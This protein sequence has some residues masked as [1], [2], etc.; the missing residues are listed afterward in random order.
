M[1][2]TI[3]G[4]GGGTMKTG[5]I[6]PGVW[7]AVKLGFKGVIDV[8]IGE[9]GLVTPGF[10]LATLLALLPRLPIPDPFPTPTSVRMPPRETMGEIR[11]R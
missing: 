5:V 8:V 4:N 6:L 7:V 9:L 10:P 11:L 2:A 1:V 3:G